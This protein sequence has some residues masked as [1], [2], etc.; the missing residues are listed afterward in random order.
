MSEHLN[1]AIG[2]QTLNHFTSDVYKNVYKT[3]SSQPNLQILVHVLFT[4][5]E[6][7]VTKV[8]TIKPKIFKGN[9][10]YYNYLM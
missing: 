9:K 6:S 1:I 2:I 8:P 4:E 5:S 3:I 7:E 10:A